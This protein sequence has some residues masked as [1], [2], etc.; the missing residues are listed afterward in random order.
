MVTSVHED[1]K[2]TV[3]VQDAGAGLMVSAFGELDCSNA[4]TLEAELG[5]AI[6]G[7][8]SGVILD[9]GGVEVIDS[10]GLRS[11]LRMA[12]HSLRTGGRLRIL[13]GSAP[14]ERAIAWGGLERL[15][16][17]AA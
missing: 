7:D 12:N 16:P 5:R 17:L 13:R 10:T 11:V 14:L 15:L 3:R 9:L 8:A 4:K 6:D 2:L 1:V